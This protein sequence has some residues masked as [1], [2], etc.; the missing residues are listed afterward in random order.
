MEQEQ[1]GG[2]GDAMAKATVEFSRGAVHTHAESKG[3]ATASAMASFPTLQG[4]SLNPFGAVFRAEANS[5]SLVR[6][7]GS[8]HTCEDVRMR[9]W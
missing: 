8:I 7:P 9:Q 4:G 3:G 2:R 1:L 5:S 6:S